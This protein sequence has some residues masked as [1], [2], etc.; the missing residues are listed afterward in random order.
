LHHPE[1][2]GIN[3]KLSKTEEIA[4]HEWILSMDK[5]GCPVRP[6]I[7]T[8]IANCL[9]KK[10]DSITLLSTIGKYW[11]SNYLKC[12]QDLKTRY[13]RKYNYERVLCEDLIVVNGFFEDLE[14][15]FAEYGIV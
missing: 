3:T 1:K 2:R 9:L 15:A 8:Q 5:R 7:V 13:I 6:S 12:Y 14:R 10:Y 4:L 11:I